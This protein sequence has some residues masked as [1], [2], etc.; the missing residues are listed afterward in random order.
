MRSTLAEAVFPPR[1]ACLQN[2]CSPYAKAPPNSE[3]YLLWNPLLPE[4]LWMYVMGY[5]DAAKSSRMLLLQPGNLEL[6]LGYHPNQSEGL[7]DYILL[8]VYADAVGYEPRRRS[9]CSPAN[10]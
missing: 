1:W 10:P 3:N 7:S 5:D 6:G 9:L 4:G 8:Q 2:P